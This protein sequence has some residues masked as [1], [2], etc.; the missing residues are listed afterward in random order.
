M[1][2]KFSNLA[3]AVLLSALGASDT[4]L[5]ISSTLAARFASPT[6]AEVQRCSLTDDTNNYELVDITSN[7]LSGVLTVTRGVE[8]TSARVWAG[9]TRIRQEITAEVLTSISLTS[10]LSLLGGLTPAADKGVYFGSTSTA[11]TYDLSSFVRSFSGAAD[12]AAFQ[13]LVGIEPGANVQAYSSLLDGYVAV[14]GLTNTE[15]TQLRKI[16]SSVISALQWGYLGAMSAFFGGLVGLTS[17]GAFATA[18]GFGASDAVAFGSI[19]LGATDTTI[20]RTGA[21]VIAVEGDEVVLKDRAITLTNKTLT[22]PTINGGSA[23]DLTA[24]NG[25]VTAGAHTSGTLDATDA[26][27]MIFMTAAVEI[28]INVFTAR[29]ALL[30]VNSTSGSLAITE[31]AGGTQRVAGSASTGS[32]T[33]AAY[34]IAIVYFKSATEWYVGGNV[35]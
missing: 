8:G 27:D 33:L 17:A 4:T 24:L 15:L 21:G 26:N 2:F 13:A 29:Q 23:V 31:G 32:V 28:P 14:G 34:G 6:G 18:L 11:F 3:E 19:E 10:S 12:A 5:V 35:S 20:A 9:G 1:S 25:T 22:S 7:P 16:D 30:L